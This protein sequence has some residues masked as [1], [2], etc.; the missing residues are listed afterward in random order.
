MNRNQLELWNN[1]KS[2]PILFQ[3]TNPANRGQRRVVEEEKRKIGYEMIG[4]EKRFLEALFDETLKWSY[5]DIYTY[6]LDQWRINIDGCRKIYGWRH[7]EI[8]EHYFE[9]TYKPIV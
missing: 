8:N 1:R 2:E 9:K 7:H 3:I 5:K 4:V 6:F